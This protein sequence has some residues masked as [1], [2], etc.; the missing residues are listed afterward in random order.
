MPD[1]DE[2]EYD[3]VVNTYYL[4]ADSS[5]HLASTTGLTQEDDT[6]W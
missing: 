1:P 3:F 5:G 2:N 6:N 4:E